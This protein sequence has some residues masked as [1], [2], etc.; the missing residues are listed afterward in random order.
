MINKKDIV[1]MA[2]KIAR[3]GKGRHDRKIMH[4][5]RE[6]L[7]GLGLLLVA[8]LVGGFINAERYLHYHTL[9]THITPSKPDGE[10]YRVQE[11]AKAI[12]TYTARMDAFSALIE[13][14][15]VSPTPTDS[16]DIT[17]E[18]EGSDGLSED[19]ESTSDTEMQSL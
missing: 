9:E 7:V 16:V 12:G 14:K 3:R 8:L 13:M 5:S 1:I 18:N 15:P 11:A 6:W 4:P 19:E 17:T 2:R 10:T